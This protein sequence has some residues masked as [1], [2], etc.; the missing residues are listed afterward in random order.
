MTLA[1]YMEAAIANMSKIELA[2]AQ[3][4]QREGSAHTAPVLVGQPHFDNLPIDMRK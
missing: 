2:G 4:D 3:I 1:Q